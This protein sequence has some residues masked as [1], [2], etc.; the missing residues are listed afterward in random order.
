MER[1][2][3]EK[4][5]NAVGTRGTEAASHPSLSPPPLHPSTPPPSLLLLSPR[6]CGILFSD[7]RAKE[8]KSRGGKASSTEAEGRTPPGLQRAK[9]EGTS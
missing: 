1:E 7:K 9:H 6:R 8:M 2:R 3:D 5:D 4:E